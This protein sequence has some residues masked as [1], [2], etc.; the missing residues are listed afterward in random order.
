M[1]RLMPKTTYFAIVKRDVLTSFPG[2]VSLPLNELQ[3]QKG[4]SSLCGAQ[5]GFLWHFYLHGWLQKVMVEYTLQRSVTVWKYMEFTSCC[6]SGVLE[7]C[8]VSP[9]VA[10]AE[11]MATFGARSKEIWCRFTYSLGSELLWDGSLR[12]ETGNRSLGVCVGC[13]WLKWQDTAQ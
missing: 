2:K 11:E 4:I 10:I 9:C 3:H 8:P 12:E 7:K 13:S 5:R 1:E 6:L